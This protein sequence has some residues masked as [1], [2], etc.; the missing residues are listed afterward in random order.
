MTEENITQEDL[1]EMF[2]ALTASQRASILDV[3]AKAIPETRADAS[4]LKDPRVSHSVKCLETMQ[5]CCAQAEA[6]FR[7]IIQGV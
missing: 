6:E 2:S 4:K 5:H 7:E 1:I 3:L